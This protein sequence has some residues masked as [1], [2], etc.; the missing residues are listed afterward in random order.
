MM[1]AFAAALAAVLAAPALAQ[2]PP[3]DPYRD[4]AGEWQALQLQQS[5]AEDAINRLIASYEAR[6]QTALQW[7]QKAQASGAKSGSAPNGVGR[8][9]PAGGGSNPP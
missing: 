2:Q 4:L 7:L 3:P 9:D 8:V 5:H 1:R 6:L